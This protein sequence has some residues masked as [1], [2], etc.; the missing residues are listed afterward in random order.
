MTTEN[1]PSKDPLD[2]LRACARLGS[3]RED[4]AGAS[5]ALSEIARLQ[6][7]LAAS[8]AQVVELADALQAVL[9]MELRGHE[10]QDRLQFS[11]PGRKLLM[12]C[13]ISI[14]KVKVA[15]PK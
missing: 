4:K 10:L 14:A 2:W 6:T 13:Q 8:Q 15:P 1:T 11:E 9:R 5:A 3:R 7:Q 12:Q